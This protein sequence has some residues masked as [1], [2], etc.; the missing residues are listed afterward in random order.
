MDLLSHLFIFSP[1]KENKKFT[2]V[3]TRN[4]SKLAALKLVMSG[5]KKLTSQILLQTLWHDLPCQQSLLPDLS[6]KIEGDAG[7]CGTYR[8]EEQINLVSL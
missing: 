3:F 2:N 1:M 4:T 8:T 5:Q 7:Y 6:R